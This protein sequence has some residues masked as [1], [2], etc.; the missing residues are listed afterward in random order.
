ME[1]KLIISDIKKREDT[2]QLCKYNLE[3]LRKSAK[4]SLLHDAIRLMGQEIFFLQDQLSMLYIAAALLREEQGS[5]D[6][7]LPRV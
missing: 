7:M 3:A 4:A 6:E 1:L 2:L 5:T